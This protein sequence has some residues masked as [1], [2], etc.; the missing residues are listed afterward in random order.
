MSRLRP[1]SSPPSPSSSSRAA[2]MLASASALGGGAGG[3]AGAMS[4]PARWKSSPT[5]SS[6][7]M[8]DPSSVTKPAP[9]TSTT[10]SSPMRA[11]PC[12]S[13]STYSP[14]SACTPMP[15]RS[16]YA[17]LESD[18]LTA[19][20]TRVR[21]TCRARAAPSAWLLPSR[22]VPSACT[23]KPSEPTRR[24][25]P[26]A[27]SV[28]VPPVASVSLAA[29]TTAKVVPVIRATSTTMTTLRPMIIFFMCCTR[30]R[31]LISEMSAVRN[32]PLSR[33]PLPL[34]S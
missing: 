20:G 23:P 12:T 17:S 32:S 31:I 11:K 4:K 8:S 16:A 21:P 22:S 18:E 33:K 26:E 24:A 34:M 1:P 30:W 19:P 28:S 13:S 27:R 5:L 2:S 7:K 15:T 29:S 6:K 3:G 14:L 25:S 10:C 9:V